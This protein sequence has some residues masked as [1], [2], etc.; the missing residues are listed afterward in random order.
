M[1]EGIATARR[2]AWDAALEKAV[3]SIRALRSK[4]EGDA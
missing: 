1:P 4:P 3:G 2:E